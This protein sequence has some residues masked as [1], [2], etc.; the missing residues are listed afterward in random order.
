MKYLIKLKFFTESK[1]YLKNYES[2]TDNV[3]ILSLF[4]PA[5]FVY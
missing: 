3:Q 1:K 4:P 2:Y 5:S